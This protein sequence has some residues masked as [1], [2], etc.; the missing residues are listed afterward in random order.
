MVID[1]HDFT[2]A[3]IAH[4]FGADN[5]KR[6]SFGSEHISA[7]L[8]LAQRKR[9]ETIRIKRADHGVF[10]HDQICETAM[11]G[12]ERF[13]E[14]IHERALGGATQQVHQHFGIGIGVE[15]RT[16]VFQLTPQRRAI[17]QIAVVA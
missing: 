2:R 5:V 11:H 7:V 10:G 13:L 1:H 15:N 6:A 4:Q 3:N 14:L 8:H 9:A 12:V 17:R 16:F